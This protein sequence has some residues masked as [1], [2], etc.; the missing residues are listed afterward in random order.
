[1]FCPG[2]LHQIPIQT[3]LEYAS[4]SSTDPGEAGIHGDSS[5]MDL[6]GEEWGSESSGRKLHPQVSIQSSTL[7][8]DD[9]EGDGKPEFG[10]QQYMEDYKEKEADF[11]RYN[12][13]KEEVQR[14]PGKPPRPRLSSRHPQ[15]SVESEEYYDDS[16]DAAY[17]DHSKYAASSQHTLS[18]PPTHYH[19]PPPPQMYPG[20]PQWQWQTTAGSRIHPDPGVPWQLQQQQ[21]APQTFPPSGVTSLGNPALPPHAFQGQ[22][23]YEITLQPDYDVTRPPKYVTMATDT[24]GYHQD[25]SET[26][27]GVQRNLH[28]S[29]E[30]SD[31]ESGFIDAIQGKTCY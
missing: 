26:T 30:P 10:E 24:P 21:Q 5:A 18:V 23:H 8:G 20:Q 13:R 19:Q 27:T 9:I 11:N 6:E 7:E 15:V 4:A 16:K 22:G 14:L 12:N 29:V 1:M 31:D 17:S 28:P 2:Y 25:P 3:S